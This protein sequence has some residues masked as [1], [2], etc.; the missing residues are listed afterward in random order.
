MTSR[1]DWSTTRRSHVDDRLD[2]RMHRVIADRPW[3]RSPRR[4]S[5][6][7]DHRHHART[8]G[9]PHAGVLFPAPPR[10]APS[11]PGSW[12]PL[13]RPASAPEPE[14]IL[15]SHAVELRQQSNY[16]SSGF[17]VGDPQ[18]WGGSLR[19]LRGRTAAWHSPW[20]AWPRPLRERPPKLRGGSVVHRTRP[21]Q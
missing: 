17:S 3:R 4:L 19:V 16:G 8:G 12:S 15:A 6:S 1:S 2:R 21:N 18:T 10:P 20:S 14:A 7:D 11:L 5:R 13:C 9:G